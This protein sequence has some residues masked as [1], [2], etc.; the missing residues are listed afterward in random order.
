MSANFKQAH[1]GSSNKYLMIFILIQI[2]F[3]SCFSLEVENKQVYKIFLKTCQGW[4][5]KGYPI[6]KL[7]IEQDF[8]HYNQSLIEID[9]VGGGFPRLVLVD[10]KGDNIK[11]Y[12]I[13][14]L[15]REQIRQVFK[16]LQINLIKPL[17]PLEEVDPN[18]V[19]H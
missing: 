5:L 3:V 16:A 2:I 13:S 17:R 11:T 7:F 18:K 1:K 12:D 15:S 4:C 19:I 14:K 9:Y 8:D 10:E 6:V